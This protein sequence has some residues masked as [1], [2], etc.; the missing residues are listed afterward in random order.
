MPK[1]T[2]SIDLNGRRVLAS[3]CVFVEGPWREIQ[4]AR[5]DSLDGADLDALTD[6]DRARIQDAL[7]DALIDSEL[8]DDDSE[9]YWTAEMDDQLIDG[10]G[11]ADPGGRSAL[12][13]ATPDNPR[14]HPCPDCGAPDVLTPIDVARGYCCDRCADR[15]ERGGY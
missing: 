9:D 2:T 10:V 5:I 13:A 15:N 14:I 6:D 8:Q 1:F 11:F 12:R 7:I 3:G 4:G